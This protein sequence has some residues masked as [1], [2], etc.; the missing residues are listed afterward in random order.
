MPLTNIKARGGRNYG[1]NSSERT[2]LASLPEN[3]REQVQKV[4]AGTID[5]EDPQAI[6]NYFDFSPEREKETNE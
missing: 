6:K 1:L 2:F 4:Y 5:V 3:L